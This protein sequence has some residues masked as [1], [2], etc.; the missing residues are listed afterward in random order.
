[1]EIKNLLFFDK[2]GDQY[3][4]Q[5]NGSYWEGSILFPGVSEKLFE[6]EHVFII[7]RFLNGLSEIKYG[8]PHQDGVSPGTPVWRTRW[9]SDYDLKIDVS[10]IIYNYELGV[11]T[12]LDAPVLI[13]TDNVEFYPE[14]VPGDVIDPTTGLVIT[15]DI[16][17]SSMQVNIALNSDTEGI[18]D[19][20][21]I[22]EDYT[23]SSNPITILKVQ[24]H[25]EVEGEDSRLS[26]MLSNFGRAFSLED[27]FIERNTDIEE[28][29]PNFEIINKKRKELLLTGESIFPYIGSYKSL[30]NAIKF[31]GFYDL[32][33]KEYWLNIH[34]D[35]ALSL[36]PLQQNGKILKDLSKKNIE[37]Q[38]SLELISSLIKDENEG[39]YKHVEIYGKTKDGNFGLKKQYE[40]IFPSKS[41]KKTALF[42]LF[43]DINEV[44]ED[45]DEDQFGYPIVNDTFLFSPEEV[46][47]K[48][49]GLKERLKRDYLPLNAR[50]IDIT[51]EGVYFNIYKTR[52]W[53]DQL[54]ID[55]I[56]S[57]IKVDFS[58]TP[59]VGYVEDLRPFYIKPNPSGLQY[60]AVEG[61]EPGISYYGNT[62][63]PYSS[64][65][66]YAIPDLGPLIG[67][68]DKFYTDVANETMPKFLGD[69]DY[70]PPGYKLFSN[71]Q[72]FVYPAGCPI[73]VKD[74]TFVLAWE[75]ISGS[76]N[77]LDPNFL[78]TT[79]D[80]A[81]YT[82]TVAPNPGTPLQSLYSTNSYT[83]SNTLAQSVTFNIG[84]GNDWFD[85][86]GTDTL[87]VRIESVTSPG[88]LVLGFASV[89]DYNTITGNL[90]IQTTYTRGSGTYSNWKV[91]PTNINFSP[92][93]FQF[94]E[95]WAQQGGFFSWDRL[96][97]L[98]FYEI[99]WKIYKEDDRPYYFE[100]RGPLP[101]LETLAH[102][103]PYTGEYN[104]QCRVWDTLNAISLGIKRSVVKVE[105]REIE[106]NTV[107]RFRQAEFY[108]W[109]DMPLVWESYPSQWIFPVE[110]Q[111]KFIDN[112]EFI[113]NFPEYSNNF[114]EGQDC[115]VLTKLPE[116]KALTVFDIGVTQ[117]DITSI[118]SPIIYVDP[119]VS[120]A[121]IGGY[122]F[123]IVTTSTP[124]GYTSG[125]TVY[126]IDPSGNAYGTFPITVLSP[127]TYEI[128]Q[129]IITPL[130]GGYYSYGAG[131]IK[132]IADGVTIADCI[133]QGNL[134]S[135]CGLI[136]NA[137]NTSV[138]S[139]KYKIITLVDSL[140]PGN[141]TFT[142][143]APNNTGDLWNNKIVVI[144][145][146]G[147]IFS[148]LSS[149]TFSG[150]INE[151]EEY[152]Y[153]DFNPS[154]NAEMK[155]WGTK[156]LSWDTFEDFEFGKAYAHTWDMYDYHND[157]LGGFDLYS[158]Q[159]G[160][161][162][163]VTE[164]S[165]GV[166][167]GET[168]S[169]PN[170][171]L[172]LSEAADQLNQSTD[173]NIKRFDYIVRNFSTVPNNFYPDE[174]PIS[175]DLSTTPGPKT[176]SSTFYKIPNFS[177]SLFSASGIAWDGDGD[178]WVSGEDITKFDGLN[179]TTYNSS[180]S[181]L[182]GIGLKTNCIK[183]DRNDVKWIGI[184]T[185]LEPLVKI[186]EKDPTQSFSY[187]VLD[188]TDNAGTTVAGTVAASIRD[189]E[190]NPQNGDIFAAFVST[191]TAYR[192]LLFYDSSCKSWKLYTPANSA[193]PNNR[194]RDLK[195]EFYG[196]NKWYLWVTTQQGLIRFDGINFKLYQTTN[197]GIPS[198]DLY[199]VEIDKLGHK[200]I[201][202]ANGLV[203][204]DNTRWAVWNNATNPELIVGRFTNIVETGN[205]NIWFNISPSSGTTK[206]YFFDGY[207]FTEVQYR[208]DGTTLIN[209]VPTLFSKS[210][211]SAPWKTI[212][213]GET[214]FPRNLLGVT[215]DGEIFKLDYVVPHIHATSKFSGT[216]GWD[217]IYHDTSNVLP[218]IEYIH[219]AA[220]DAT[221]MWFNYMPNPLLDNITLN[222][223]LMRPIMPSVDRKSWYKPI[224]QRYPIDYLKDQF[225]SLDLDNVF[226]YAPLRDI[227]NGKGTKES[228][229]KN[230]QIERIAL[231]KSR[232][233][234][235]N[236]EWLITQGSTYNDQ[237]IKITVDSE[238]NVIT[239]GQF[240][241]TIYM[242]SV[243]N[244]P[245]QD[246]YL[247]SPLYQGVYI[248]K[249]NSRGVL[250]WAK[251][252][253]GTI[254]TNNISARSITVDHND[255]I[256]AV[257]DWRKNPPSVTGN[258]KIDKYD[259]GGYSLANRTIIV[260]GGAFT[261]RFIGDIKIDKHE[262]VYICGGFRGSVT[263]GTNVV[264]LSIQ[265]KG[266]V[267]K[268]D[269]NLDFIWSKVLAGT[270]A[271]DYVRSHE[272][273][274]LDNQDVFLTGIFDNVINFGNYTLTGTGSNDLFLAKLDALDGTH[275]WS[276]HF[277]KNVS[278]NIT[279]PS[280]AMD[281]KGHILLTGSFSGSMIIENKE[282][283]SATT[284]DDIF[285]IKMLSTGKLMWIKRCGGD[286]G[287]TSFD[288]ESDSDENVY[289][290]GS[291]VGDSAFSPEVITA[292]GMSDLYLSKF[293]K[294]GTL[295][296]IVTAGGL[297]TDTGS[298]L[299]LDKEENIYVT[300]YFSGPVDFSPYI[301]A[302]PH[303]SSN[304]AFIGKIPKK[305]FEAGN[306]IGAVQSWLGSHSWSWREESFYKTEFEIPLASTIFI[307][308][309]N[310]LIPGKKNHIWTLKDA[311]T[312][313]VIVKVRKTPYFIWTFT[314]PGFYTISCDLE[315]ANGNLYSAQHEGKIRVIDH[316]N[317][318]AGDLI[319]EIVTSD[320]YLS[321]TIYDNRDSLGFPPLN[322]FDI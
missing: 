220:N 161:R 149:A 117:I 101:G 245:S 260:G 257:Y 83:L 19:R 150:G 74:N 111:D 122:G 274:I 52:G 106:L 90:T 302:S 252:I 183:V 185:S 147:C 244:I 136:Y 107:T 303:T 162:V 192:G 188:F 198:N 297:M 280:I 42:G 203:Y 250:Q 48:L 67:A 95:N 159:Y 43:Y 268:L 20:T 91:T 316:K 61:A 34:Q 105:K 283:T 143:Q 178:I 285:V 234:F 5:Y 208:N 278:T 212:K 186:N 154:P 259:S 170:G 37:G 45:G 191:N 96:P 240:R 226:L 119:L 267:A 236:F 230:S 23:D 164:D 98:D 13:K 224:W 202:T 121:I 71:G 87:F 292:R 118:V 114:S 210:A 54:G 17:S 317:P 47:L 227:L 146:T 140:T 264:P 207:F 295:V 294:D 46:L 181:V 132:L 110:N 158:L 22:L 10:S 239:I 145:T 215:T 86:M 27:S 287:D 195:L 151:R 141:K 84:P 15:S 25:G 77:S 301:V 242:G 57:G 225:P 4:F 32:R 128:P 30:F 9:E 231:K 275:I 261:A 228:Y 314:N 123:A 39:K 282:I 153:Y 124:H 26:V 33:I 293:D 221:K 130:T 100:I 273:T 175:P 29:F 16:T 66:Q 69:G 199:S 65:Q 58:V 190:I 237:G 211:L 35:K 92:Y 8:F 102:F 138:L 103:L 310:S 171:Y 291:F 201:G 196:I 127:T 172:D 296:D 305:R 200:W 281:I 313:E 247:S 88:N 75:E 209:P 187:N 89:G 184:D 219:E 36:T 266:Y 321:R 6:I 108:N 160:D 12:T 125:S 254:V 168:D 166:V 286:L 238:G 50:I 269:S 216:N 189:L 248:S 126:I 232:N 176:I 1:M 256:Y 249:Y 312:G 320:D 246:V 99:E 229:W 82:S 139:P 251:A 307:N 163:R 167:M 97:Y 290:T 279:S 156:K 81:S 205:A 56:K 289:I 73:V 308:P 53:V 135:T 300:G 311:F 263:F 134:N 2:K 272:L 104:I 85:T 194:I 155:F 3:N 309:I 233:L 306:K 270:L 55:D 271:S 169:P 180:N 193:L 204:W 152:V 177:P 109:E 288:I 51:G 165:T 148:N 206:L 72:D 24:L 144:Q 284:A 258:M 41:Y 276:K 60:P 277:G 18:Y 115:E 214:T 253:P 68:I 298:D 70:D 131:T 322:R 21:L 174:T 93:T 79:L 80:I 319:P 7:E 14:V 315:D 318:E 59:S 173:E 38:N 218:Q 49:F 63:E 241:G 179:Y 62:I 243:N 113:Q 304:D 299:I 120:P 223:S 40:E 213:N 142:L 11:D 137:V 265:D 133:F 197:S 78:S 182:P 28:P 129:I 116:V 217:F 222:S 64:F 255:N 44:N 94:F 157:W 76:W 31:F 262:N 112:T 235:D